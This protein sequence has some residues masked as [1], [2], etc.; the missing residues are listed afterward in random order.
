MIAGTRDAFASCQYV[1]SLSCGTDLLQVIARMGKWIYEAM[2]KSY[3]EFFKASG[4]MGA[5]GW[6]GAATNELRMFLMWCLRSWRFWSSHSCL[7][8]RSGLR[9]WELRL[10]CP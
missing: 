6:E 8:S 9:P 5:A 4:L 2:Y 7:N 3:L 10:V 1:M